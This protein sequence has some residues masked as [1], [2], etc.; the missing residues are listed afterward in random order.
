[1]RDL[2]TGKTL[3]PSAISLRL[4]EIKEDDWSKV[5]TDPAKYTSR[6]IS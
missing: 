1:M 5:V 2:K 3:Y 4:A 6:R